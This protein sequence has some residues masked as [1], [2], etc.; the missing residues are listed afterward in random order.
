VKW[1]L[2]WAM[3]RQ[4]LMLAAVSLAHADL[5]NGMVPIHPREHSGIRA[6]RAALLILTV[7]TSWPHSGFGGTHQPGTEGQRGRRSSR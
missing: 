1:Q 4:E 2:V 6:G 5:Q 7:L 3:K